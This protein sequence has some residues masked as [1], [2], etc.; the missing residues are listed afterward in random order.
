MQ[1]ADVVSDADKAVNKCRRRPT[2]PAPLAGMAAGAHRCRSI[3][4]GNGET[5]AYRDERSS[6]PRGSCHGTDARWEKVD[7]AARVGQSSGR[8]S[9]PFARR[10]RWTL[11]RH[12]DSPIPGCGCRPWHSWPRITRAFPA[13][14]VVALTEGTGC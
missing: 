9:T 4:D 11:I 10:N 2:R 6:R 7:Q 3:S 5:T 8:V 1:I 14:T 13:A 12:H